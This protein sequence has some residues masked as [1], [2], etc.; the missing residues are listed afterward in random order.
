MTTHIKG[1]GTGQGITFPDG[2]V[3]TTKQ[4][5]IAAAWA[6]VTDRPG[7]LT[8]GPAP[9][10]A[11]LTDGPTWYRPAVAW[12]RNAGSTGNCGTIANFGNFSYFTLAAGSGTTWDLYYATLNCGDCNCDCG[13]GVGDCYVGAD[14]S[15]GG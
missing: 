9:N 8:T 14:C 1:S 10:P 3:Q 5:S 2:S 6:N 7:S 12:G 11:P 4:V 13:V 15:G